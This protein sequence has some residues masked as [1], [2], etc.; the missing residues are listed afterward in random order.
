M[1]SIHCFK[2]GKMFNLLKRSSNS[3]TYVLV[4]LAAVGVA[5]PQACAQLPNTL[6]LVPPKIATP[7]QEK[8]RS[9]KEW[10]KEIKE[11][12]AE[13]KHR[14]NEFEADGDSRPPATIRRRI[15]LLSR[16]E[17]ALSQLAAEEEVASKK[18]EDR[19]NIQEELDDFLQHGFSAEE[20]ISFLQ[21]DEARNDLQSEQRRLT[22][23]V[24]KEKST[25]TAREQARE[26]SQK[27]SSARRLMREKAENNDQDELRQKL[28]EQLAEAVLLSEVAEAT[29]ALRKQEAKNATQQRKLKELSI[30]L[31][32][33]RVARMRSRALFGFAELN[34]LLEELDLQAD[35][36]ESDITEL[37][38]DE[39]KLKYLEDQWIRARRQLDES[40][41]DKDTLHEQI[42]AYEL[43]RRVI[44]ERLPTLKKQVERLSADRE[45]WKRRQQIFNNQ[46]TRD[47][48]REWL[49]ES[50][51]SLAQ[52]RRDESSAILEIEELRNQL[53]GLKERQDKF[54]LES[55]EAYWV[56]QQISS[57]RVLLE[58]QEQNL[59]S[60][61]TSMQLSRKVL[62]ELE[63]DS[64]A[65]TAKD[66]LSDLWSLVGKVW[67]H[68][69]TAFGEEGS[70]TVQK[71]VT[72][73]L[74]LLAGMFLS[75]FLSR[76]LRRQVLRRLDFDP[77]AAA[78]IQ[79]LFYY[80]LLLMFG[81]FALNVAKVPLT[82]FTVLGGAVALGVGFGSQN[83]I[84]NF[85]SGLVMMAERPVKVGD[86]IQIGELYGNIEHIGARSTRVR[87]GANLEIIVPNSSFL[88]DNVINFTLSSNKVRTLVEVGV[89]YG[90]PTVTVTQLLRRAA[91]ETGRVSKDPP[92]IILF[93]SFGD[94]ALQFEVHFWIHMRTMMDQLQ[95]ESA[96][97]FLIDQLFR[98]EGIVI[99]FPQR[100]VHLDTSS[101]LTIQMIEDLP[102]NSSV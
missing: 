33:E 1:D 62:D 5:L 87:T 81:L 32:E 78:T 4:L 86:L 38:A 8:K 88:Q 36:L 100:D 12:L 70:V 75:R 77:S 25:E 54:S 98:E 59:G 3:L 66:R 84:N 21:L 24:D 57:W 55:P 76:S 11:Q 71:V 60:I 9:T 19:K 56:E 41:G 94:N 31:L 89:L 53:S 49:D 99:A 58:S 43:G 85:I 15:E 69:L 64:L 20:R 52:F 10:R 102:K 65:D 35:G 39:T 27:R 34:E 23:L 51:K 42:A 82:A 83:I 96:V 46:T 93:K 7:P 101:P 68:E 37:E 80:A 47:A 97:R 26:D 72:A 50:E 22:R 90:S 73:L 18:Q 45:N 16:V 28:G 67:N 92:P 17:T 30:K 44:R 14:A 6:E 74:I 13:A 40:T 63:S 95:I 79:S 61:R 91:V 48:L 29:A 2:S